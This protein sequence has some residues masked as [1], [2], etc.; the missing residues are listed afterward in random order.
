[1]EWA[2]VVLSWLP[3]VWLGVVV[4][5]LLSLVHDVTRFPRSAHVPSPPS[6]PLFD[7]SLELHQNRNR[8]LSWLLD[9]SRK[10]NARTWSF[11]VR[12]GPRPHTMLEC[13]H[14]MLDYIST[15]HAVM[16]CA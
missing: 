11:K 16:S 10:F 5:V 14:H 9:Y 13:I 6:M 4:G 7:Q 1:M 3:N 15:C 2:Q 12:Q 8:F